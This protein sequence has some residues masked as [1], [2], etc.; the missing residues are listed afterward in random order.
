M[1]NLPN[2]VKR[3]SLIFLVFILF[4]SGNIFAQLIGP[5]SICNNECYTYT[6]TPMDGEEVAFWVVTY[7][8]VSDTLFTDHPN[9]ILICFTAP[10][11]NLITAYSADGEPLGSLSIRA[12][13]FTEIQLEIISPVAC[14]G[15]TITPGS[16]GCLKI[17]EGTIVT[18]RI[19]DLT[20][21]EI[22]W[23]FSG[24]GEVLSSNNQEITIQ[25]FE[26]DA[27]SW[28][29][30]FG[31]IKEGC[32]FEG[33]DCI[34]IIE[35]P[36]ASF[37][38][39][40]EA[41]NDTITVC[42]GQ[43]IF[44][45]STSDASNV[46]WF[47]G[48]AGSGEGN[49]FSLEFYESGIFEVTQKVSEICDCEDLKTAV[50]R[51]LD[52][53]APVIYCTASVCMGDTATYRADPSCAPYI[54]EINGS[55]TILSGGDSSDDFIQVQWIGGAIGTVSLTTGCNGA[56]PFPATEQIYILGE[57]TKI[58]GP[59]KVCPLRNYT[60][61]VDNRDG[62]L[63]SWSSGFGAIQK[64]NGTNEI[65]ASF[66]NIPQ[67]PWVAVYI[68]DCTRDCI[69]TDTLW[70]DLTAPLIL[71]GPN[72]LC[73]GEEATYTL[74]SNSTPVEASWE[75]FDENGTLVVEQ[76][77]LSSSFTFS[78]LIGGTFLITA[79]PGND[80]YCDP[81][82][83]IT[84]ITYD[85]TSSEP[86]I[87]GPA[88][89]CPSEWYNYSVEIPEDEA[90]SILWEVNNGGVISEYFSREINVQWT[91]DTNNRIRVRW[92]DVFSG[93]ESD[94]VE[95]SIRELEEIEIQ[96]SERTCI[97]SESV[98]SLDS[99]LIGEISW[100][101][102]NPDMGTILGQEENTTV[103]VRWQQSGIVEL[104]ARYC[105]L[106]AVFEIEILPEI[107]PV[108]DDAEVCR[109][110]LVAI[111][112]TESYASY[113]WFKDGIQVCNLQ[114]C[115]LGFGNYLLVVED[116]FG[117]SG[118]TRFTIRETPSIEVSIINLDPA[119]ICTGDSVRI[120][121][122]FAYDPE[123]TFTWLKD[124]VPIAFNTDSLLASE[125][126]TYRLEVTH[127][128]SNCISRSQGLVICENCDPRTVVWNC[129]FSGEGCPPGDELAPLLEVD[130]FAI[131]DCRNL[132]FE[133]TNFGILDSTVLWF[134]T[135]G[136][137]ATFLT[138]NPME[139]YFT[140]SG[141]LFVRVTG[142]GLDAAGDTINFRSI[143]LILEMENEVNFDYLNTCENEP[144]QFLSFIAPGPTD[145]LI[146]LEWNFGDP[147]SGPDNTSS[148]INPTH[149]YASPGFY[150][151]N[152]RANFNDCYLEIEKAVEV[153]PLPDAGFAIDGSPC[154]GDLVIGTANLNQG[155]YEWNFLHNQNPNLIQD[156][157]NPGAFQYNSIGTYEIRLWVEDLFGCT[158]SQIET[159]EINVFQGNPEIVADRPFPLCEGDWVELSVTGGSFSS[160]MWNTG[161]E[162]SS[163]VAESSGQYSVSVVDGNDC[164]ATPM[165]FL[166]EYQPTPIAEISGRIHGQSGIIRNDTLLA[167]FGSPIELFSTLEETN[168]SFN[169]NISEEGRILLFDGSM[170]P[171]LDPGLH[172][173]EITIQNTTSGCESVSNPFYV[174]IFPNPNQPEIA[175][176][177]S[178]ILC[179]GDLVELEVTNLDVSL[180][181]F[182]NTGSSGHD[183]STT[184]AGIYY[185]S[186]TN[187][188]GC[189]SESSPIVVNPTPNTNFFPKGC[190]EECD[191]VTICL[192]IPEGY[193]MIN[194][195][196]D[197]EQ[198]SLP[199][200]PTQVPIEES[201]SYQIGVIN[202]NGCYAESG[203]FEITIYEGTADFSGLV[204]LD[205]D[206]SG[207]L[208]PNDSLVSGI[209]VYLWH[210]GELIDS[211]FTDENGRYIFYNLP[212][213]EYM[214][215]ISIDQQPS[216]WLLVQDSVILQLELCALQYLSDPIIF[217][218]CQSGE[219][220]FELQAC[221]GDSIVV[222]G[223]FYTS[224]TT[225]VIEI[226]VGECPFLQY[227]TL[228]FFPLSDTTIQNLSACEGSTV[229]WNGMEFMRDTTFTLLY[230][231]VVGCD[232]LEIVQISFH[233]AEELE[234]FV[235]LCPG[236]TY[237]F[238][239]QTFDSDTTVVFWTEG[240][241]GDC[242]V[243]N[244]LNISVRESWSVEAYVDL[245]CPGQADGIV[246]L[247]F[248]GIDLEE[249]DI[250]ILNDQFI[251]KSKVLE[252]LSGGNYQLIVR[253]TLGCEGDILFSIPVH[254]ELEAS[255]S[256]LVLDCN[257]IG[258]YI[259][260]EVNSG[261]DEFLL[262][263]WEDGRVGNEIF[264]SEEGHYR[265]E[266]SNQCTLLNFSARVF[267]DE[268]DIALAYYVPN[269]FTPNDDGVNDELQPLFPP[270]IEFIQ[271]E[272]SVFDRWGNRVFQT[273]DP[274]FGWDG[275]FREQLSDQAVFVWMLDV[276]VLNCGRLIR[277]FDY[278][279]VTVL[280]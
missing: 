66:F 102:S 273:A 155:F 38:T 210:E 165:L 124:N 226:A 199:A 278:G 122:S 242:G 82:A 139:Y 113:Q 99:N 274:D 222:E 186:A 48:A 64:G 63:F 74:E 258:G 3:I 22:E 62:T 130:Y 120:I 152:L 68:E 146:S 13:E 116:E 110:G 145:S 135:D 134:I 4:Q 147:T 184:H 43:S 238:E 85:L 55:A 101:L 270:D 46:E 202:S 248:T 44:F 108:V 103:V 250:F 221:K 218:E 178:G 162:D 9:E 180:D 260:V 112:P 25:F 80:D 257:G 149:L 182:W 275:N 12:G 211:A 161:S 197:G 268:A 104:I 49:S 269:A 246:E 183:F 171:L 69:Q 97:Y 276:H 181:Y 254:D 19:R 73:P 228:L 220:F 187:A 58:Q 241:D 235:T 34:E 239:G 75:V 18:L 92:S 261:A 217:I 214:I 236:D 93:C 237:T 28:I 223:M 227:Y 137:S 45:T 213:G 65:S 174:R 83:G 35:K 264:V 111:S 127:N 201:G 105:G 255:V 11:P 52:A 90:L 109:G 16:Q 234:S 36:V 10:N 89:F 81:F 2:M 84:L 24:N 32:F 175:S 51:V 132:Q 117:C 14:L 151:V 252:N 21:A 40:P 231:N 26:G 233:L 259:K 279:D 280:R 216:N 179:S 262:I 53:D 107:Q 244:N 50:I 168:H 72:R 119:G 125:F 70:L 114:E 200:E 86:I 232:S 136:D 219:D 54:W 98:F 212:L 195:I 251:A 126:G 271:F 95:L 138:G 158:N 167:C 160:F 79:T 267:F 148:E 17:C 170:N 100:E 263:E 256:D 133:A 59:E 249:I 209:M 245:A 67:Q 144:M 5:Q 141:P 193:Q 91:D 39:F 188:W 128:S 27:N 115:E 23:N 224:D 215:T 78:P 191:E 94:W 164:I 41:E 61:R 185:V 30:Y 203:I 272:F 172:L 56:C 6:Y 29:S 15:Q 60:F 159:L 96:G 118:R 230:S 266:V 192:P 173:F 143:L 106:V 189:T 154:T 57:E 150:D 176:Q 206:Q 169:W 196:K 8:T 205:R 247:N 77:I 129:T 33:G 166:V 20:V 243:Y 198:I 142:S 42:R 204:F 225:F 194:W 37:T 190:M 207:V 140:N 131:G 240:G 156:K 71:S 177:A 76:T 208:D 88:T 265:L 163:I 31:Q 153:R 229:E 121:S 253:D 1:C 87:L 157:Q 47:A 123:Y 277:V 7:A